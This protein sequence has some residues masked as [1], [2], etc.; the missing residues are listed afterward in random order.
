M[1][2]SFA[3]LSIGNYQVPAIGNLISWNLIPESGGSVDRQ[4]DIGPTAGKMQARKQWLR[5]RMRRL[6]PR[7]PD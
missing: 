1:T 4:S 2:T 5:W 6:M 7:N 3:S